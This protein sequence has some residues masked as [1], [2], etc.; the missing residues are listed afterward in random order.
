MVLQLLQRGP[1]RRIFF[2]Y[3]ALLGIRKKSGRATASPE[4][5]ANCEGAAYGGTDLS[6]QGNVCRSARYSRIPAISVMFD[7]LIEPQRLPPQRI[8]L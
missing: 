6:R 1:P 5:G 4:C 3:V 2:R 7:A 8:N